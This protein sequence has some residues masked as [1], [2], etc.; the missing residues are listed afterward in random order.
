MQ[1]AKTAAHDAAANCAIVVHRWHD[2]RVWIEPGADHEY[3]E[4]SA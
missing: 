3:P 4:A 1:I 2:R